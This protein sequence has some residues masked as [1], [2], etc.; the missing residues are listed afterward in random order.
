MNEQEIIPVQMMALVEDQASSNPIVVLHDAKSNRLLPIWIGDPEARAIAIALNKVKV[1][2]P[3]THKLLAGV[4]TAMGGSLA[5]IVIDRVK[6]H[7][8]F[9]S[10]YISVDGKDIKV[11]ARPSDSIALALETNAP[12]YV[13]KDV[14]DEAAQPNPFPEI[15]MKREA[16]SVKDFKRSDLVKLKDLLERARE[17]EQK[18]TE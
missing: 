11:D 12:I 10:I 6:R 9:A 5:R 16:K 1:E 15:V 8:Y 13:Q 7:T 14:M 4:I 17:R 3:L 18:S 2:R